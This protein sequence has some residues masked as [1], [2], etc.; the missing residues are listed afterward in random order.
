[1]TF[2]KSFEE[3]WQSHHSTTFQPLFR[4]FLKLCEYGNEEI[5]YRMLWPGMAYTTEQ[6]AEA[7]ASKESFKKA[8]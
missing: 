7:R 4:Q 8:A 2:C 5:A 6:A 3:H 1:M